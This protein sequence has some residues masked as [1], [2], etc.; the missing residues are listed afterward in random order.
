ME[1][2]L[3]SLAGAVVTLFGIYIAQSVGFLQI[4]FMRKAHELNLGRAVPKL[5]CDIR[6]IKEQVNP[7]GYD[8]FFF[9]ETT[10]HNEGDF[11][12]S[13]LNGYWKLISP[14]KTVHEH[15]IPIRREALGGTPH[16]LERVPL[17]GNLVANA[18]RGGYSQISFHVDIDLDYFGLP[19]NQPQHYTKKSKFD[20]QTGQVVDVGND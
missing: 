14:D 5:A 4:S 18:M 13:H 17:T 7:I 10:I 8:P 20:H 19:E 3:A 9:L 6:I 1:I 2:L 16:K 12:A 15:T 11:P